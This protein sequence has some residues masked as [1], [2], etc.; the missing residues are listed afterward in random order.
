MD[1]P[2]GFD[3]PFFLLPF[4]HRHSFTKDLLGLDGAPSEPDVAAVKELKQIVYQGFLFALGLGLPKEQGA[5]LVDEQ[6]GPE[7]L[8]AAA[9]AEVMTAQAVE[10]SG[11]DELAFEYG[12]DFGAHLN[13]FRPTFAKVLLRYNPAGD[14]ALNQHQRDRLKEL[15]NFCRTNGYKLLIEPLI[16][17]LPDQL[18]AAGSQEAFDR[19][20]RP[21][22]AVQMMNDIQAAGVEVDIWKIEGFYAPGD[23]QA[24]VKQARNTPERAQVGVIVLGRGSSDEVVHQWLS[25]GKGIDGVIG[26]AIGRTIF[27]EPL[28]AFHASQL[29]KNTA[30]EQIGQKFFDYYQFFAKS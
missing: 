3:R 4:D 8:R 13:Q 27:A 18:A 2:I 26:F 30:A 23:Y 6:F 11:Q 9:L 22:L 12:A 5:V 28:K 16:P 1:T 17:A 29:A 19:T 20:I 25:A 15:S 14:P 21:V 24:V 10:K 7:I